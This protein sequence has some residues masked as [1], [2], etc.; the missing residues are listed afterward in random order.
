[1]LQIMN[2]DLNKNLPAFQHL[3]ADARQQLDSIRKQ[4]S[5][6]PPTDSPAYST[7]DPLIARRLNAFI[8]L[9]RHVIPDNNTAWDKVTSLLDGWSQITDLSVATNLST[10][11]VSQHSIQ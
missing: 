7:F 2:L 1:M 6:E 10:W 11:E 5:S 3:I 8:P 4:P 9:H